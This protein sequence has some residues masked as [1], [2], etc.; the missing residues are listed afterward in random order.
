LPAQN[1]RELIDAYSWLFCC[2]PARPIIAGA[3][4]IAISAIIASSVVS[5]SLTRILGTFF[6]GGGSG[7]AVYCTVLTVL[8]FAHRRKSRSRVQ[9]LVLTPD[10]VEYLER[11]GRR[12]LVPWGAISRVTVIE[13]STILI[14]SDHGIFI[15]SNNRLTN[16][17]RRRLHFFT[18]DHIRARPR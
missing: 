14:A 18:Q 16:S 15:T 8:A 17:E 4:V 1:V 2:V 9:T 7:M 3:A 10:G 13:E 5:D 6:V 11:G 12:A